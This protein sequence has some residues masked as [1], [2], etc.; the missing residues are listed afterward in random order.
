MGLAGISSSIM[1]ARFR[2]IRSGCLAVFAVASAISAVKG[3][4]SLQLNNAL[5]LLTAECAEYSP[6]I[7][8][9]S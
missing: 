7:A 9:K 2:R 6:E 8:E 3:F 4:L 5:K 1:M